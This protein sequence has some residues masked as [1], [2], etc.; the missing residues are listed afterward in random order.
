MMDMCMQLFLFS[1]LMLPGVVSKSEVTP[2][3]FSHIR[4]AMA[5]AVNAVGN[6]SVNLLVMS[7]L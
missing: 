6:R 4:S 2:D 3:T 5:V 7:P 1:D